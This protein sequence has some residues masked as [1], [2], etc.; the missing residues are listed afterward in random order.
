MAAVIA[1][2]IIG[3]FILGCLLGAVAYVLVLLVSVVLR[4]VRPSGNRPPPS[5]RQPVHPRPTH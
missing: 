5:G 3:L 2:L 4:R 1:A